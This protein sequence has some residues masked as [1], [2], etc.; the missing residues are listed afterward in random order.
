MGFNS[1]F[2]GLKKF[3]KEKFSAGRQKVYDHAR[4]CTDASGAYFE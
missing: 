3:Q 2:K 1:A 4:A